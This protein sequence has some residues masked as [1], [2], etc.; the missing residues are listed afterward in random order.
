MLKQKAY[1]SER[2]RF[3]LKPQNPHFWDFLSPLSPSEPFF[4]NQDLSLFLPGH[5]SILAREGTFLSEKRSFFEKRAPN[6][7][8]LFP[9]AFLRD[10]HQNK[11]LHNFRKGRQRSIVQRNIGLEYA[12]LTL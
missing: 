10:L 3:F 6:I 8:P 4:K 9:I 7:S 2:I 11:A 1:I 5:S 12:L